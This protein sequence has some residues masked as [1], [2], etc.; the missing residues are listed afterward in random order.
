MEI[1]STGP[2]SLA[3]Y[4]SLSEY[5]ARRGDDSSEEEDNSWIRKKWA[6]LWFAEGDQVWVEETSDIVT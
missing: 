4:V 1:P 2:Q 5:Q 3:S 6:D